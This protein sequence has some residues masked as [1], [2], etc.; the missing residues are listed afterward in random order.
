MCKAIEIFLDRK[1]NYE[2][3]KRDQAELTIKQ[4]MLKSLTHLCGL[5][6]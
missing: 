6:R 5:K 1:E 4:L 3:E 2:R